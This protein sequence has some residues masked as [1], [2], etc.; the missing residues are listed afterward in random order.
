MF[1]HD[2]VLESVMCGN[3]Q[4]PAE[5]F[6]TTFESLKQITPDNEQSGFQSQFNVSSQRAALV[7]KDD[8]VSAVEEGT[9]ALTIENISLNVFLS[10]SNRYS[11]KHHTPPHVSI[12]AQC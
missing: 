11:C 9:S 7:L 4:I 8:R 2:A 5:D 6:R 3:T 10:R 12:I 1:I